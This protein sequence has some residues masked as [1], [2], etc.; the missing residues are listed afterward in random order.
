M[1]LETFQIYWNLVIQDSITET[2]Q[3]VSA[4]DTTNIA[5]APPLFRMRN[6]FNIPLIY[7]HT[8][9]YTKQYTFK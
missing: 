8:P 9:I 1:L 3:F 5:K 2:T 7:R 6:H 4:F